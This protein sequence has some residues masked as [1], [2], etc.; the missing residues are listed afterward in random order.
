MA[1]NTRKISGLTELSSLTGLEY[2]MISNGGKSYKI[3]TS[4]LTSDIIKS[5]EQE[6]VEGDGAE[7]PITITTSAGDEYI[8]TVKNGLRGTQGPK[9]LTGDKGETG[10]SGIALY[11]ETLEDVIGLIIDSLDGNGHTD[12]ELSQMILSAKQGAILNTKLDKLKEFYCTQDQYDAW[13]EEGK[14]DTT[15]KYFIVE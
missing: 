15:A 6:L 7:S 8:F 14:I 10:N 9:G 4:L 1:I 2:L 5:I 13:A 11:N 3:R 12:D